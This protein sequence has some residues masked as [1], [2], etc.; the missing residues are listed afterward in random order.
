M[1]YVHKENKHLFYL[2]VEIP[3]DALD[4]KSLNIIFKCLTSAGS[5]QI[6][7]KNKLMKNRSGYYWIEDD[8]SSLKKAWNY[9]T[10][11][12]FNI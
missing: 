5:I 4:E 7:P 2:D 1:H 9:F 10:K 8:R 3:W 12:I 11:T 6:N